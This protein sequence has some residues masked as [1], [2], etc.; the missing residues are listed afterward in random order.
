MPFS[1]GTDAQIVAMI[2]A[3]HNGDI[4]LQTDGGWSIG[5]TRTITV[6]AFAAGGNVSVPSQSIDIAISS[7]DDYMSCGCV[8]QFDFANRIVEPIRM[9]SSNTNLGGYG[10]SEMKTT[11]L[12][13]L[14]NALPSWLKNALIE[15]SVLAGAGNQSSTIET[16]TGNKLALRSQVEATGTTYCSVTGEGAWLPYYRDSLTNRKKTI[17]S[18]G[19]SKPWS[20]RSP[21]NDNST[22]FAALDNNGNPAYCDASVVIGLAPF[23]CL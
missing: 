11:T 16:V 3:A 1:T 9:N 5:D 7:F 8:L 22:R 14:V 2:E 13:A 12:P 15:F 17:K 4:D 20:N 23:G 6:D 19:E 18:T 10:A 21:T